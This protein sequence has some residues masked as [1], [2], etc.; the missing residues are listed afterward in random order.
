MRIGLYTLFSLVFIIAVAVGVYMINPASVSFDVLD[1]H[2]PKLPIAVWISI[3]VALLAVASILHMTFYGTKNF[4]AFRKWKSDIKKLEDSIYWSLIKEPTQSNYSHNELKEAASILAHSYI[5]TVDSD[6]SDVSVKFKEI[7]K[8]INR[9]KDG[10]YVDLKTQKFAKHLSDNNPI[11]IQNEINHIKSDDKYA[12]KVVDF[13]DKYSN[14][15]VQ[16]ALDKVVESKDF[17][18]LKKYAKDI[19]KDRFLKLLN[20]VENGEDIGFS[21][22]MLKSFIQNYNLSCEDYYTIV[23]VALNSFDPDENLSYFK[24]LSENDDE[25]ITSYLYLLFKYEM[26]DKVDEILDEH[27]PQDYKAFRA[28]YILKKEKQ[29]ITAD[30]IITVDNF[31]K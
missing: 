8:V 25:A 18:T 22:D 10:E 14:E 31:C 13:R 6:L 29:N 2:M 3:P 21:L 27:N 4:F 17:Y 7:V 9:I 26:L 30:D 20:R 19:G 28:L 15:L 1:I 23:K 11:V 5:E 12:L 16:V 24:E